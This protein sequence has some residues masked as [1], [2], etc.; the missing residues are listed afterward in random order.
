MMIGGEK[1]IVD[2]LEPIFTT[3][4]PRTA[5]STSAPTAPAISSR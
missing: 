1:A 2:R 4:A 5:I 3:L